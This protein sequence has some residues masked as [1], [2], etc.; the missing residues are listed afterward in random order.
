MLSWRTMTRS[1]EDLAWDFTAEVWMKP[2]FLTMFLPKVNGAKYPHDFHICPSTIMN[3]ILVVILS[4]SLSVAPGS[5]RLKLGSFDALLAPKLATLG[6]YHTGH[7]PS[8]ILH[9]GQRHCHI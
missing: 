6:G 2:D 3:V 5:L 1:L 9:F 8:F 4:L 7:L